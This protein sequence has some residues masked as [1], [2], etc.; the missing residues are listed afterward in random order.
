MRKGEENIQMAV[1]CVSIFCV[2]ELKIFWSNSTSKT[3]WVVSD[4]HNI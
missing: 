2:Y 1:L 3:M 4:K